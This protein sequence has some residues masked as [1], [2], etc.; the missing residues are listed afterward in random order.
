MADEGPNPRQLGRYLVLAQVGLEMVAPIG[1]G[2]WLDFLLGWLPWLT[3][4]GVLLGFSLGLY[5]IVI[6]TS[7][8]ENSDTSGSKPP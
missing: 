3:V 6:V 7:R 5:H 4:V 1:L 8:N 2:V